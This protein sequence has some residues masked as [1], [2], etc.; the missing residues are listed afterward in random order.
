MAK[1]KL[2]FCCL[3]PQEPEPIHT[4]ASS[5]PDLSFATPPTPTPTPQPSLTLQVI[6]SPI[7]P[8]NSCIEVTSSGLEFGRRGVKDGCAYFGSAIMRTK[9]P[10][11]D[12]VWPNTEEGLGGQHF[13]IR[14][15]PSARQ[16]LLKDM[17]EGNGT[18]LRVQNWSLIPTKSIISFENSHTLVEILSE[19]RLKVHFIEG[20]LANEC[21]VFS[22]KDRCIFLGRMADCRIYL[23]ESQSRYCAAFKHT[24]LGWEVGDGD[25]S[26]GSLC[27]VWIFVESEQKLRDTCEFKAG[28]TRFRVEVRLV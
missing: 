4:P 18:F 25:G 7:L 22:P 24:R 15:D 19:N 2:F 10:G 21:F 6:E 14:F 3:S 23:A 12:Y 8:L 16:F 9:S 27:G 11:N 5:F 20:P 26:R 28:Q 17:G 13:A 1:F